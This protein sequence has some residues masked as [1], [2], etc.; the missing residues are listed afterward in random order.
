MDLGGIAPTL[1]WLCGLKSYD[2][3]WG[4][5]LTVQDD[6]AAEVTKA[7]SASIEPGQGK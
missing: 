6:I 7:L 2:R 5:I 4:D 1:E 3:P